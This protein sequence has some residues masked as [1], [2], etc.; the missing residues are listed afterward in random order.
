MACTVLRLSRDG[1]TVYGCMETSACGVRVRCRVCV[2]RST[3]VGRL[4]GWGCRAPGNIHSRLHPSHHVSPSAE[5]ASVAATLY[6]ITSR[7]KAAKASHSQLQLSSSH[8]VPQASQLQTTAPFAAL[9]APTSKSGLATTAEPCTK[10]RECV[11]PSHLNSLSVIYISTY[12]NSTERNQANKQTK[13]TQF[14]VC[15]VGLYSPGSAGGGA[16]FN[17]AGHACV[18]TARGE[19]KRERKLGVST[20]RHGK[21]KM[22]DEI[23]YPAA[24]WGEASLGRAAMNARQG[25]ESIRW[26]F[27]AGVLCFV[28]RECAGDAQFGGRRHV[29]NLNAR[30]SRDV[31]GSWG[32]RAR[33]R[34]VRGR[35]LQIVL[36]VRALLWGGMLAIYPTRHPVVT[37]GMLRAERRGKERRTSHP[38]CHRH[39]YTSR[40]TGQRTVFPPSPFPSAWF[41]YA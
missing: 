25:G 3:W 16:T 22:R 39:G 20:K 4:K 36:G 35:N 37:W 17:A 21:A 33:W 2:C 6:H 23:R 1:C 24:P 27:F 40:R 13:E 8:H 38:Q 18:K 29:G 26:F 12:N 10:S 30:E 7:A 9:K 11:R 41:H 28:W 19:R 5:H 15:V 31:R 34:G 32:V 14:R